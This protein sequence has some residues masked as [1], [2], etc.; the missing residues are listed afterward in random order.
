MPRS[1][2]YTLNENEVANAARELLEAECES[3]VIHFLHAYANPA[4][5]LHA[6]KIVQ[7]VCQTNI[8]QR[9]IASYPRAG[10]LKGV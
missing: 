1:R 9:D 10:N 8:S 6:A 2:R 4:H 3:V 7:E 5:E